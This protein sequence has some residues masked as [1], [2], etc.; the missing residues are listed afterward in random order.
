MMASCCGHLLYTLKS[1]I[2]GVICGNGLVL[3]L[4]AASWKDRAGLGE[5]WFC[6][7]SGEF[8]GYTDVAIAVTLA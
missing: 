3:S 4:S 6:N 5:I 7:T 8:R 2:S 1:P